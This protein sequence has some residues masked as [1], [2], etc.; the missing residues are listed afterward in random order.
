[1]E[2]RNLSTCPPY[3]YTSPIRESKHFLFRIE[4]DSTIH[5]NIIRKCDNPCFP[6]DFQT[7]TK[8]KKK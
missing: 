7:F 2:G 6:G 3:K 5:S 8:I 1:M 4:N